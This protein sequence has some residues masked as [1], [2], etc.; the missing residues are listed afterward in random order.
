M[1][2]ACVS[3]CAAT[4]SLQLLIVSRAAQYTFR[5]T[6]A[7]DTTSQAFKE[8][9]AQASKWETAVM[10]KM[11]YEPGSRERFASAREKDDAAAGAA[12]SESSTTA[13]SSSSS[14]S[15]STD[16]LGGSDTPLAPYH[17]DMPFEAL[18]QQPLP[19]VKRH[20]AALLARAENRL[21]NA[22]DYGSYLMMSH[23]HQGE[24]FLQE[25]ERLLQHFGLMTRSLEHSI[26]ELRDK[27]REIQDQ[28]DLKE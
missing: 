17:A 26:E 18:L 1:R 19:V 4:S 12:G 3:S 2:R 8:R 6:T 9:R 15:S 27:A 14:S 22:P 21:L 16:G 20:V 13:S 5:H 24:E 28:L 10:G 23:M 25:A 7:Y 11:F